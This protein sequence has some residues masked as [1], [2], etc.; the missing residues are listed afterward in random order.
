MN[1]VPTM[2]S[3]SQAA[4]KSLLPLGTHGPKW[5]LSFYESGGKKACP[6]TA[7]AE[8]RA[9]CSDEL[10]VGAVSLLPLNEAVM[11]R[12]ETVMQNAPRE[13]F[14]LAAASLFGLRGINVIARSQP[15]ED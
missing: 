12:L 5:P 13:T 11:Q 10:N 1:M 4:R 9:Q 7:L 6:D 2:F 3:T 14:V 15:A 8:S